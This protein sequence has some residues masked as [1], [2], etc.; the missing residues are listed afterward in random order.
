M[1]DVCIL[2]TKADDVTTLKAVNEVAPTPIGSAWIH[3]AE[4]LDV[5]VREDRTAIAGR[6]QFGRVAWSG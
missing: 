2:T 6:Q 3:N 1:Y 5:I 4:H